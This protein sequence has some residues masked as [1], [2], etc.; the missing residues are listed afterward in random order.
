[1]RASEA[2]LAHRFRGSVRWAERDGTVYLLRKTGRSERSLGPRSPETEAIH[3]AFLSGRDEAKERVVGLRQRLERMARINVAM[4]LGRVPA[5]PARILRKLDESRLLGVQ[6]TIIGTNALYAYEVMAGVS[7]ASDMLAT[8]DIDLLLDARRKLSLAYQE[9]RQ[10]GLLGLLKKVD[11]SFAAPQRR[12][13]RAANKDGYLVE[14]VR[15]QAKDVFRDRSSTSLSPHDDDLHG[16]AITGLGWLLNSPKIAAIAIDENGLP[17]PLS[18]P[19]P[20]AFALHKAW[21]SQRSDREPI[22]QVRDLEQARIVA[23]LATHYLGLRFDDQALDALPAELRAQTDRLALDDQ[24]G[25]AT[26]W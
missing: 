17:V 2:E 16:A 14:L 21:L 20:R 18:A 13:Y 22:K 24:P 6:V 5:T 15:P 1:L 11:K 25:G 12:G 4:G 19:D 3:Q 26:A 9:I 23:H 10:E 8:G 7:I